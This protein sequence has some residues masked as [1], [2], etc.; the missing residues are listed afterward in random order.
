MSESEFSG[1]LQR[2]A[3]GF[4]LHSDDGTIY[5]LELLRTPIDEVE[6]RVVVTGELIEKDRIEATGVRLA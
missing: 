3:G 4:M 1:M 5:R 6:K 2:D